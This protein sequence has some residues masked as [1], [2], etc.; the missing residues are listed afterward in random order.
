MPRR[1]A[2]VSLVLATSVLAAFFLAGV[3]AC[4]PPELPQVPLE[5][6]ADVE[7]S[8]ADPPE[9]EAPERRAP[10]VDGFTSR[11][12][13]ILALDTTPTPAPTASTI[14]WRGHAVAPGTAVLGLEVGPPPRTFPVTRTVVVLAEGARRELAVTPEATVLTVGDTFTLTLPVEDPPPVWVEGVPSLDLPSTAARRPA[15]DAPMAIQR[16]AP[17]LIAP[18]TASGGSETLVTYWLTAA[19]PGLV[20]IAL[21]LMYATP[22]LEVVQDGTAVEARLDLTGAPRVAPIQMATLRVGD[23]VGIRYLRP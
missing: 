12:G 7:P 20:P 5:E 10:E 23:R 6:P 1:L 22:E 15:T 21:P 4:D 16:M 14:V 18:Q 2:P 3:S 9:P 17:T 8:E 13:E 19:E 11:F